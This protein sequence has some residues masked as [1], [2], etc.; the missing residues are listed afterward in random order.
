MQ[1]SEESSSGEAPVVTH[2]INNSADAMLDT[3]THEQ[4]EMS[5]SLL[6]R[7]RALSHSHQRAQSEQCDHDVGPTPQVSGWEV[8]SHGS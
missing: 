5:T 3:D 8:D 6:Q 2:S 4:R 7:G 1:P